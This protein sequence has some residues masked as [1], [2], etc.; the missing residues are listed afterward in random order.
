MRPPG[1][2]Q[3]LPLENIVKQH[4]EPFSLCERCAQRLNFP[5]KRRRNLALR[6]GRA[7]RAGGNPGPGPSGQYGVCRAHLPRPS[8]LA[9]AIR[10]DPAAVGSRG[11]QNRP[12]VGTPR[13]YRHTCS[14]PKMVDHLIQRNGVSDG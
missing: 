8:G 10:R 4:L 1:I 13:D 3:K 9:P 6:Q 14:L 2:I 12:D 11:K 7:P 5:G